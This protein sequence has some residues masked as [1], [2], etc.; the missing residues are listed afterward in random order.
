MMEK[1]LGSS[2]KIL[3]DANSGKNMFY[4]PLSGGA[5]AGV[6][7][8]PASALTNAAADTQASNN[9]SGALRQPREAVNRETR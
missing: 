5:T 2:K 4:L 9:Y 7:M 1:V 3:L 8:P 6:P